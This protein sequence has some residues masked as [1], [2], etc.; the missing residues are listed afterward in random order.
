VHEGPHP[1]TDASTHRLDGIAPNWF[2]ATAPELV[3]IRPLARLL[4]HRK[5]NARPRPRGQHPSPGASME[6]FLGS[7]AALVISSLALY[8]CF[9]QLRTCAGAHLPPL[10]AMCVEC[11]LDGGQFQATVLTGC[12]AW[13]SSYCAG[14]R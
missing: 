12:W 7:A 1:N 11:A 8:V 6:R 3:Q 9:H 4:Q 14:L 13:R 2:V 5:A 10:S